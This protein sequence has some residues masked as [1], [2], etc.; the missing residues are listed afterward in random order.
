MEH[1]DQGGGYRSK[2]QW[3]QGPEEDKGVQELYELRIVSTIEGVVLATDTHVQP[4]NLR[5]I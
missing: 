4:R 2:P 5:I 3:A 1:R